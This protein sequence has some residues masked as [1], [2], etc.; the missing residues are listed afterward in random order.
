MDTNDPAT[1]IWTIKIFAYVLV[2]FAQYRMIRRVASGRL[3]AVVLSWLGWSMLMGIS[4]GL[5]N[6]PP[7]GP[8]ATQS[9]LAPTVVSSPGVS[10]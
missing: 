7:T 3:K 9:P 2:I 5:Q 10:Q 6:Q 8:A 4:V 1:L